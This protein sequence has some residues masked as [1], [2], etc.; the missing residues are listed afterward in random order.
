ME[1]IEKEEEAKQDAQDLAEAELKYTMDSDGHFNVP[2]GTKRI[3]LG[4]ESA[5]K[6]DS[7]PIIDDDDDFDSWEQWGVDKERVT[8]VTIPPSVTKIDDEAFAGC[9]ALISITIPTSV[10][11]IGHSVFIGCSSLTSIAIPASVTWIGDQPFVECSSLASVTLPTSV[12]EIMYNAFHGCSA[13]TSVTIPASVTGILDNAFRGCSA[14]THVGIPTSVTYIQENAFE[15][16]SSLATVDVPGSVT[17][18]GKGAFKDCSS[19]TTITVPHNPKNTIECEAFVGCTALTHQPPKTRNG[20]MT[21]SAYATRADPV[22]GVEVMGKCRG[23]EE[24]RYCSIECQR[25]GWGEHGHKEECSRL[26]LAE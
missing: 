20:C 3:G 23:C 18:I 2:A 4:S 17:Y 12:T 26:H 22:D 19:M 16:C 13:L 6:Y 8:S 15:G 5:W 24:V 11:W 25:I 14:L 7:D 10:T 9:S 1:G 21:C